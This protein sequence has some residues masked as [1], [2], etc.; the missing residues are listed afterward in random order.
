MIKEI[1]YLFYL[2]VLSFFIYLI[3]N[4]YFSDYYEKKSYRNISNFLDNLNSKNV[5]VP[6]IKN[7]TKSII[8][9]KT[10]SQ[11]I[12]NTKQRKFWELIK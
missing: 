1:K 4:Y 10:N 12:I 6:L 8:E 7:D 2:I 9:Y 3:A 5:D 11:K